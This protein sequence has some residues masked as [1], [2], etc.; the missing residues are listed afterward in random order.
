MSTSPITAADVIAAEN[1]TSQA[2]KDA[3]SDV[4]L[5]SFM[6]LLVV[7]LQNQDPLDPMNNKEI[8]EQM[9]QI[10]EI[11]S[12]QHLTDTLES[13]MLGQTVSTAASLLGRTVSALS[14]NAEWI[15]GTVDKISIEDGKPKLHV[16]G[17]TVDMK[18]ISEILP[19]GETSEEGSEEEQQ[20]A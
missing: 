8:L 4:S 12:N 16:G 3:W 14:D 19:P 17:D 9:S 18:N 20:Q 11:E 10:R 1:S 15:E 7:E 6:E 13:V 5:E 2:T